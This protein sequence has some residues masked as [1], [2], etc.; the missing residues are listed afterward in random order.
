MTE[1]YD[2]SN[3]LLAVAIVVFYW[4]LIR[5]WCQPPPPRD[6]EEEP[7]GKKATTWPHSAFHGLLAPP[8]RTLRSTQPPPSPVSPHTS[9]ED[10]TAAIRAADAN[11]DEASFLAGASL[12]YER[13]V[14]A[15]A[16]G[17]LADV[18]RLLDAGVRSE[19]EAAISSG[20]ERGE[21]RMFSFVGIKTAELVGASA[22]GGLAEIV[23]RFTADAAS[24]TYA[25]DG[26]LLYGNP[27]RIVEIADVWTFSRRLAARDPNWTVVAT[28]G[29]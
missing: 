10:A 16:A 15:Y 20:M 1:T 12:A 24:A 13:V 29:G 19:F 4:Q 22:N 27:G 14:G 8:Q 6:R 23:V 3:H 2:P 17:N 18:C 21:R 28:D 11:F 5:I 25:A 7:G 9:R 26:S